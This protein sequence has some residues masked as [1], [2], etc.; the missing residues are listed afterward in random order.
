MMRDVC[1]T[2]SPAAARLQARNFGRASRKMQQREITSPE[3]AGPD[4]AGTRGTDDVKDNSKGRL[5]E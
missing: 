3:D 2:Y 5:F 1:R 4:V